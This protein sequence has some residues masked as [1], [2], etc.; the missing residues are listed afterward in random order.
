MTRRIGLAAALIAGFIIFYLGAVTPRPAPADAPAADFSAGR[1]FVDVQAMGAVPHPLGSPANT[2]V[3]DY[4]MTRMQALGLSPQI[5]RGTA[6][7]AR[8]RLISGGTV[9]N[10]VGVLPGRDR[11][12]PALALMAHHDSVPGSPG[13]AD[14]TAGVAS[15][16]EIV[17]A[18][19]THGTPARDVMVVITD[20]EEVGL[21]GARAFFDSPLAAHVGYVI[22]METRGGGGRA[23]MF[24]TAERDGGDIALYR[25]TAATPESNALTVFIYQHLPNDTDFTVAKQHGKVGLNYAFIGRQFDYHSPSSTPQALDIGSLQHMGQQVLPTAVA[26]AFGPLPSRAPDVV[27]GNVLF[28]LTLAYPPWVGWLIL[29]G[30]VGLIAA[31]MM[32]A[33]RRD[34]FGWRDAARGVGAGLYLVALSGTALELVR[35][36]T[37]VGSGWMAY[38]PLLARFPTFEVMMLAA[39]L[40][41]LLAT[42]ALI[43]RNRSRWIAAALPLVFAAAACLF[44]GVDVLALGLGAHGVLMGAISF[45]RPARLAGAWTGL[46]ALMLMVAAA[47][48]VLAPTAAFIF[49]WP[50]AAACVSFAAS[51]GGASPTLRDRAIQMLIAGLTLAWIGSLMHSLLVGLDMPAL[52]ILPT[53]LAALVVWPLATPDAPED[54]RLWPAGVLLA[55]SGTIAAVLHLTS[56]WTPRHPVAAEPIFVIDPAAR[57]AWRASQ[58]PLDAWTRGVLSAEGGRIGARS[59]AFSP[60]PIDAA[61]APCQAAQA[62]DVKATAGPEGSVTIVATPHPG[63]ARLVLA[64]SSSAQIDAVSVNGQPAID[65][66]RGSAPKPYG[67]KPGAL[68]AVIW[69]SP[70][71]L[72]VTMH[73]ANPRSLKIGVT[74]IYGR[75]MSAKPL[76]PT[77]ANEQMWNDAGS[78]YV[79]GEARVTP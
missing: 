16:L 19:K 4:L 76:P 25:R 37:G 22:N 74:E 49:A 79:V 20:G 75:W 69:T 54:A 7:E 8:G 5:Q 31:G 62:P 11:N 36:A 71:T 46:L 14:D 43:S 18:L 26:L 50:L 61:P 78:T 2:R 12:A 57:A 55:I 39:G 21:L 52:E 44:G 15:A 41:A 3:R 29:G 56:P 45:G 10:V 64:L 65:H 59:F 58:Q 53:L 60:D 30:C 9:E 42:I 34:A 23:I 24:E 38:R 72:T 27:Y 47:L 40:A 70:Q 66:P 6:F 73:T 33:R 13:A 67:V 35:R 51:Q 17:R 1:A 28:G 77:P 63:A 32:L 68:G 48:Q